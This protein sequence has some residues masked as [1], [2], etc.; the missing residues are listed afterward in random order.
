[1]NQL[2][3]KKIRKAYGKTLALDDITTIL[4][5]GVTGLLGHNGAG[6]STLIQIL[7]GTLKADAGQVVFNGKSL[8]QWGID[9][10][11]FISY[12]PQQLRLDMDL[13]VEGFLH[14]F[15]ALKKIDRP[16]FGPLLDRLNLS[17][18]KDKKVKH[19][20]GGMKQRLLLAQ[21][22]LNQPKILFLDEPTAGLDPVE[23]MNLR[24]MLADLSEDMII[25]L[26]THVISD[27]EF[28]ANH[29][30]FLKDG[31]LVDQGSQE[32]F[33][34]KIQVYESYEDEK[35]LRA[36]DPQ[37]ILVNKIRHDRGLLVR[38]ISDQALGQRVTTGLDDIY[39]GILA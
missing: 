25:L 18:H 39:L 29:L 36:K 14:Y 37:L 4:R 20:S 26:A 3:I 6:K 35:V 12:V 8:D 30:I 7:T 23:R 31:R 21:A 5:P 11:R 16:D 13:S 33:S 19:L 9:Y 28:I 27:V 38:F 34:A 17:S 15:A 2:E 24:N 22:L 32:Y 1:M 10:H